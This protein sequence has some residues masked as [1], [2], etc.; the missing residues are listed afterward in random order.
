MKLLQFPMCMINL[1][2]MALEENIDSVCM[3]E[4]V[5]KTGFPYLPI[6]TLHQA[7]VSWHK[8]F[9]VY[10]VLDSLLTPTCPTS[11]TPQSLILRFQ[12]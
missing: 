11:V 2:Q 6:L 7:T 8:G 4:M 10:V 1:G 12:S 5:L 3:C 9:S